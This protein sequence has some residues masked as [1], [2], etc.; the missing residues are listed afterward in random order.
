MLRSNVSVEY[1]VDDAAL[2]YVVIRPVSYIRMIC[3]RGQST[4]F[5]IALPT[6]YMC[7]GVGNIVNSKSENEGKKRGT[8]LIRSKIY[9]WVGHFP[10]AVTKRRNGIKYVLYL[11]IW[12]RGNFA[13]LSYWRHCRTRR[14]QQ[15]TQWRT[16][17]THQAYFNKNYETR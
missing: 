8:L 11:F 2:L 14:R 16:T 5:I 1:S 7:R 13:V 4:L 6:G 12:H 9:V 3:W 15:N 10:Q 17:T